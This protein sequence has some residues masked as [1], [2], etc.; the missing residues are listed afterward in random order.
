[1]CKNS[2]VN[3]GCVCLVGFASSNC[4]VTANWAVTCKGQVQ[5]HGHCIHNY[6]GN[7]RRYNLYIPMPGFSLHIATS[8]LSLCLHYLTFHQYITLWRLYIGIYTYI[9]TLC[10]V[11][12][13]FNHQGEKGIFQAARFDGSPLQAV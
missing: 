10:T 7:R 6:G 13:S 4:V 3:Y 1:M 8:C 12:L 2:F 11:C 5:L 9:Y